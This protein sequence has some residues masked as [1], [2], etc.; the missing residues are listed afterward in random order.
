MCHGF[1]NLDFRFTLFL[2]ALARQ[3]PTDHNSL[4]LPHKNETEHDFDFSLLT[5]AKKKSTAQI[6]RMAQRAALRGEEYSYVAPVNSTE[7]TGN[8]NPSS[9]NEE[10]SVDPETARL[11]VV[12]SKL[13]K[14][15]QTIQDDK[16]LKSKDRRTAVRK[17]ESIAADEAGMPSAEWRD[18][19]DTNFK[20]TSSATSEKKAEVSEE[21]P[22]TTSTNDAEINKR[23]AIAK[24]LETE[25]QVIQDDKE[26]KAKERRSA[27]RKAEA[28]ATEESGMA[29][30]E[31]REWYQNH[32]K[33]KPAVKGKDKKV[34]ANSKDEQKHN[35]YIAFFGQ[36][37]F[38][39][40]QKG[41]FEH[42]QTKLKDDFKVAENMVK[43]RILTDPKTKKSRGMAFVEVDDPELLYGLL[44]LHQTFLDGRR[45]NVERSAG[46]SKNSD[47]RK[48]KITQYRKDQE[49]YFEEVVDK[50]LAEYKK[51]GELREDELDAG[52]IALCK[53][54][55]AQIV[56]AA[57]AKYIEGSGRDMDNPSAYLTFLIGKFATE[58]I[59]EPRDGKEDKNK[60]NSS[61][62]NNRLE[63]RRPSEK[64]KQPATAAFSKRLKT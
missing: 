56:E 4:F 23:E 18:W 20:P 1:G 28:I 41:L 27:V 54:H 6:K 46:G 39:T 30:T 26:M 55:S 40:T 48:S 43:I 44:K 53:R 9:S 34:K 64:R 38:T 57:L 31:L 62:N 22:D 10:H 49:K 17:A 45:L 14:E 15:L 11:F 47:T 58:G 5:M 12:A 37:S 8:E 52:V 13:H 61:T 7:E 24:K 3:S 19:Y 33:S 36:L 2:K 50:M 60:K 21:L 63:N 51:T 16:T 32:L 29:V 25:L 35:P 42:I 59:F